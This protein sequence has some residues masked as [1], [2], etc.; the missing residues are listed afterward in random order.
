MRAHSEREKKER[1][2]AQ[3]LVGASKAKKSKNMAGM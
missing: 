1:E 3:D 2:K